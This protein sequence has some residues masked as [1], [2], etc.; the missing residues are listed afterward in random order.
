MAMGNQ[1]SRIEERRERAIADLRELFPDK[2]VTR[3]DALDKPLG[4]RLSKLYPQLGFSTRAEMIESFGFEISIDKGGRPRSC[5]HEEVLEELQRRYKGKAKPRTAKA[6][7]EEN[8]DL[9][10]HY[11][12]LSNGARNLFG[13]TLGEVLAA[14][15]LVEK[16]A[17]ESTSRQIGQK[18]TS[19]ERFD[20]DVRPGKPA[21]GIAEVLAALDEMER[22]LAEIP[23]DER[24]AT[25]AAL[26]RLFPEYDN[27]ILEGRKRGVVSKRILVNRG[28][29]R[30]SKSKLAAERKRIRLSHIRN[31]NL[32]ALLERYESLD[33]PAFVMCGYGDSYLRDGVLGF[34]VES[35]SELRETLLPIENAWQLSAGDM[36]TVELIRFGP[37]PY[38]FR[39]GSICIS[40]DI[41]QDG[42]QDAGKSENAQAFAMAADREGTSDDGRFMLLDVPGLD[43]FIAAERFEGPSP[44]HVES[45]ASVESTF[46]LAG[47]P[48]AVL[49]YRFVVSLSK[50]TLLYALRALGVSVAV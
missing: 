25:M 34:D 24:P 28:I 8:P 11:K 6:L 22:R 49:R 17:A 23:M 31:Q 40:F 45:G 2:V 19:Q 21:C 43:E 36:P 50:E 27:L 46:M 26:S 14:R 10:E 39:L 33:G 5:N 9:S 13:R 41:E 16:G 35:M 48:L 32:L 1:I 7:F 30:L 3:L 15:G 44:F 42:K 20:R 37:R 18:R 38:S 47:C 4:K 29:L 12:A